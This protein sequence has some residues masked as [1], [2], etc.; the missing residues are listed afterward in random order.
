MYGRIQVSSETVILV[1]HA[2]REEKLMQAYDLIEVYCELIVAR[3]SII[4]SQKTCPIDLKEA[5]A[6][7]IFASMR[8]ADV[9]ELAD[10]R[11][12]FTS[13]Y[14]KEFAAAALEVRPDSGVNR[15]VIE[16]LS[17]GAPD[18]QT[19]IKTLSSI[20]EE[21]NIKW[22]PKAFEEKLQ[23]PN[24]D[25]LPGPATYC[26]GNISTMGSFTSSMSAPQPTYSGVS[27]A[28]VDSA[29]SRVPTESYSP[30]E[31]SANNAFSQE[32]RRGSNASVAPSF[33]HGAS[34]HSSAQ[35]PG[36]DNFSH[37]NLGGP[38]ISK[39]YSQYDAT[40]PDTL[41]RNEEINLHRE[42]KP[43]VSGANWNVEFKDATSAAQAAA[44][45]AE[46]ASIAARAAAQ[47]ASRGN[48]SGE[49]STG[50]YD[51]AAYSHE[52]TLRKQPAEHL[53]KD[54]KR[55]FHDHSSGIN[56]PRVISSNVRKHSGGAETN[57]IDSQNVPT[58]HI[59]APFHSHAVESHTN[60]YEM[61]TE[62]PCAHSPEP[63]HFDDLYE[64]E[65]NIGR[66]AYSHENTLMKQPAENLVKDETRSFHDQSSGINDPGVISSNVRKHSGGAEKNRVDNQ[67][68]P[69][70]HI[71]APFHSYGVES[72]TD[73]YEM[74]TEPPSA[75][76][77][78]P[79]HFDD[80]YERESNIGGS[81]VHQFGF[82]G[83]KLQD[84]AL[85]GRNV[86]D[87]ELR[88]SSS[89]QESTNDHYGNFSSSHG[90]FTHG[91][92]T[93]WDNQ[94][95]KTQDNSSAVVFDQYD[96]DVAEV[97]LFDTFSSKH[98]D[99]LPGVQD[100]MG[101]ST[102]DWS[103]QHRSES[104][105]YRRTST[106]FSRTET[107]PSD[108]LGANRRDIPSPHSYDNL[109]PTFDSDGGS[110]D[111]EITTSMH[112][113]SL[114]SHSRRSAS[115]VLTKEA[116]RISGKLVPDVNES[117]EDYESSPRK[118]YGT[119]DLNVLYKEPYGSGSPRSGYSGAQG[120]R[121]LNRVQSQDSDLSDE[122]TDPDKLKGASSAGANENQKLPFSMQTSAT[123]DD[124]DKGGLGLNFERLTPGLRNK[125]RQLPPYTKNS[126]EN[127]LPRQSMLKASASIEESVDSEESI[128]SSGQTANAPI[129]SRST[130]A[131]L[132]GNYNSELYDR[133]RSVGT[134]REAR[135]TTEKLSEQS[136]NTSPITTKSSEWANSSQELYHEK[137]GMGAR[138]EMRSSVTRNYFNSDDS[139]EEPEQQQTP[140]SKWSGQQIQSRRTREVTSDA[141][142]DVRVGTGVKYADETES[143]PKETKVTQAFSN[144]STERRRG[145][146][147]YSRVGVQQSSPKT[148][149]AESPMARGKSQEAELDKSSVPENEGNTET[150]AGTPKE[151][152]PKTPPAHVH[153][154]L[155]TDYDSFAAH[156]M[157]LRTNRR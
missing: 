126:R 46:M 151:S 59:P 6:S 61:P 50:A 157:S 153:P 116:N 9:T 73:V 4:D 124:K 36:S 5:I 19:K 113:E 122:E 11:K 71:P 8:C 80:L 15:L 48:Y 37:G 145:G 136:G 45:S 133:N 117:V 107:Q 150:S 83:E 85:G 57:H 152:T 66:S 96:S 10:V 65:S 34:A 53:V 26:G 108:N 135:S 88:R 24:E 25:L 140:K 81:E 111:E 28:T 102:A 110:S 105:I 35:I 134:S 91:S 58:A 154:K 125:P 17:A 14:G 147:V 33:Q 38:S 30:A 13:K 23:K 156:F 119:P 39:P 144:S 27:V 79:P 143:M 29:T 101:F 118:K 7:V 12:H 109:P 155:P 76:S 69:T 54:G 63:P 22:E 84:T 93:I 130:R 149:H 123:S 98:T 47:L 95:D 32:H 127:M 40:V 141:K 131:S 60:V 92:S 49:Q 100:H 128:T 87:V 142:R 104:P 90:T 114:R 115:S 82:P 103:K 62:P 77:P 94:N 112:A 3:L 21:H 18:V 16:K 97:N 51:S 56:D 55:S 129:S 64:R 89:D 148:E 72:Y 2:I 106:L 44:E 70:T 121:N 78:E 68:M 42:R 31:V 86:K 132:G 67:N 1:E 99:H 52:N 139:E 120:Q 137:P 146:P 138:R 41:S 74:P 43:S 20:A 75:H